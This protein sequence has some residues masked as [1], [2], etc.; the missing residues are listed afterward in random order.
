[1][2]TYGQ[3]CPITRAAEILAERWTLVVVRN[4]VMGCRTF[5]EIAE[6]APAMSRSLLSRR[7]Q[8]LEAA[9]VIAS[10]DNP[11][12]RGTVWELTPMG[13]DLMPVLEAMGVWGAR[14]LEMQPA[15]TDPTVVL[16][17]WCTY[18]VNHDAVPDDRTV[19]RFDVRD[20]PSDRR[21]FWILAEHHD[22]EVCTKPPGPDEHLVVETDAMTLAQWHLGRTDW[23]RA[24]RAGV[25]QVRGPRHLA[26]AV[27]TWN[28]R[29]M[30]AGVEPVRP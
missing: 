21:R 8:E 18:Y 23:A 30:F 14:W 15:H 13:Q 16:W 17:S 3:Y 2:R 29:S 26:R 6:G 27:P 22:V 11:S 10:R 24:Q 25:M 28:R 12:G 1:M 7:L 4:L 5:T 20:Q 9:G 19:V